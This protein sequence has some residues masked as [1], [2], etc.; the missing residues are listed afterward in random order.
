MKILLFLFIVFY[1]PYPNTETFDLKITVTNIKTMKGSIELGIFSDAESFLLKDK[2]LRTY[3]KTVTNDTM[4]FILKDL[5]AGDYAIS[6]YPDINSDKVCNLNFIGIPI[7]PYGFSRNH[8][9]RF[10]K[11]TFNDCKF[12][13]DNNMSLSIKLSH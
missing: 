4:V 12:K 1:Y 11:P 7:E 2:E 5:V 6:I 10:T 8:K 13:V 3:S 9:V